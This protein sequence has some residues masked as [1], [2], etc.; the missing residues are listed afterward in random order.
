MAMLSESLSK[1]GWKQN[2]KAK[3]L[4]ITGSK[5][6]NFFSIKLSISYESKDEGSIM[7]IETKIQDGKMFLKSSGL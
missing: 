2:K 1:V 7:D 5:P 4:V 3:V 6:G